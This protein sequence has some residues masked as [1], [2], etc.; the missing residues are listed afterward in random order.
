MTIPLDLPISEI[1]IA[2]KL[3]DSEMTTRRQNVLSDLWSKVEVRQELADGYAFRFPNTEDV[4]RQ[5]L[6]FILVERQCCAFFKI[7]LVFSPENGPTWLHLRGGDGVKQF[8]E[9]ELAGS[10]AMERGVA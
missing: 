1:P 9:T 6:D 7:E 4:A 5:L 10:A 2:C 3:S 8:V